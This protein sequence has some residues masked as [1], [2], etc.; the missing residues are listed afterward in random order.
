VTT[1][2]LQ[3]PEILRA[4]TMRFRTLQK[5]PSHRSVKQCDYDEFEKWLWYRF[6]IEKHKSICRTL[7]GSRRKTTPAH[8]DDSRA[9][10][11]DTTPDMDAGQAMQVDSL[12]ALESRERSLVPTP[13]RNGIIS[14]IPHTL[15]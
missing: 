1:V 11:D 12:T 2:I 6:C 5:S 10:I 13:Y 15:N 8:V 9:L 7:K 4:G 14:L 3:R